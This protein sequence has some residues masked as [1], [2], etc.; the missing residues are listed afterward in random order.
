MRKWVHYCREHSSWLWTRIHTCKRLTTAPWKQALWFPWVHVSK[1]CA[2]TEAN[3]INFTAIKNITYSFTPICSK[4]ITIINRVCM[5][6]TIN[7]TC[8]CVYTFA[9]SVLRARETSI[10]IL[11]NIFPL[12]NITRYAW[13]NVQKRT[14]LCR[15]DV[16]KRTSL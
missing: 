14:S 7:C 13:P 9:I 3:L 10:K 16:Q 4:A 5:L 8:Y 11:A 2:G 12:W 1:D 15:K 6:F